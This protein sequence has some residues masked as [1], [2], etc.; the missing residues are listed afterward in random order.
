[1]V[2]NANVAKT[3]SMAFFS[4]P[5]TLWLYSG[6]MNRYASPSAIF[7]FHRFTAGAEKTGFRGSPTVANVSHKIGSSQS[8]RSITSTSNPP[9][10]RD[11][12]VG[13]AVIGS[14][15][16]AVVSSHVRN[17]LG[18]ITATGRATAAVQPGSPVYD[19]A[20][21]AGVTAA[22]TIGAGA[23]VL[24]LVVTLIAIRVRREDLQES[25]LV[26]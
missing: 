1:L 23:T 18:H 10:S 2:R 17:S 19:H 7:S 6:V 9:C 24:A 21:S 25:P 16:W 12:E 20:L 3:L 4:T 26:M 15:A 13:L 14:V 8:L 11:A 5:G 22:L